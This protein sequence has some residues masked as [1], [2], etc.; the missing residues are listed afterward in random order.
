MGKLG[1]Y[2][3]KLNSTTNI[4]T[5]KIAATY[6]GTIVGA[7]FASGQEVLQ[8]FNVYGAIGLWSILI[9]T[10]LFAFFG[11]TLLMLGHKL[12]AKSHLEVIRFANGKI[13]GFI[14]DL[15]ITI[16]LFGALSAMIAGAGAVF[17]EQFGWSPLLGN[18]LMAVVALATVVIGISGVINAISYVVPV[19]LASIVFVAAYSLMTDPIVAND[20]AIAATLSGAAPNWILSAVNYVSYN[21]VIAVAI[22]APMGARTKSTKPLLW[23]AILGGM[24]L[25]IGITCIY[26]S[27][28][29]DIEYASHMEIPMIQIA[30]NISSVFQMIFSV[31]L[32]AEIY[33]TAVGNLYGFV[34]RIGQFL[35]IKTNWLMVAATG[36][37]FGVSQFGFS[38]MVKY[39]YP[40]VGYGGM[41]LLIGLAIVWLFRKKSLTSPSKPS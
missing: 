30:A 8:Y 31:I 5:F 7:G 1:I 41:I 38:N 6:M 34:A 37:A 22:L 24:S 20:W 12:N 13:L 39:L 2:L 33:T 17:D 16:F 10:V 19:L 40:M 15:I 27:I 4:N 18:L 32:F 25:G 36:A 14:V 21:L 9:T 3:Q 23:G 28:L 29:T 26:L 11:Y 35:N